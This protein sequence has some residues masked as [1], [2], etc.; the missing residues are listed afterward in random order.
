LDDFDIC[1]INYVF[2][3]SVTIAFSLKKLALS[4][5]IIGLNTTLEKHKFCVMIKGLLICPNDHFGTPLLVLWIKTI[6]HKI[7]LVPNR[8]IAQLL[9]FQIVSFTHQINHKY[10]ICNYH[11]THTRSQ[12]SFNRTKL[13][14]TIHISSSNPREHQHAK[15]Q[16]YKCWEK[17][18]II[19]LLIDK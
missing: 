1:V 11:Q 5:T 16:I 15:F 14:K 12:Q 18:P 10:S 6:L 19:T 7:N 8:S 3:L 13:I 4:G 2:C 17:F 9:R